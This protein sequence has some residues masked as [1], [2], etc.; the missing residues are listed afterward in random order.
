MTNTDILNI[1]F[2]LSGSI[3]LVLILINV[4]NIKGTVNETSRFLHK[5]YNL[6]LSY[7]DTR[8]LISMTGMLF[9]ILPGLF[10]FDFPDTVTA[11]VF[12][13]IGAL[14]IWAGI[15]NKKFILA[16]LFI[17]PSIF[18][19]ISKHYIS[20]RTAAVISGLLLLLASMNVLWE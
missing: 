18:R 13:I 2:V 12:L 7:T 20:F 5:W 1:L 11:I 4:F 10:A 8:I 19:C 17:F 3:G 16:L 14:L 15:F 9:I 6:Q